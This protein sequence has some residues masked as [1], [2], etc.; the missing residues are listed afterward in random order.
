MDYGGG[1]IF[2]K[3]T[4]FVGKRIWMQQKDSLFCVT[5]ELDQFERGKANKVDKVWP[6][7]A[8]LKK[9]FVCGWF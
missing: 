7:E 3:S 9:N 2:G 8:I 4:D 1:C 6:S 5:F